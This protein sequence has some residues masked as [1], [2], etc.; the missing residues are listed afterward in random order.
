MRFLLTGVFVGAAFMLGALT[1]AALL[2]EPDPIG[3]PR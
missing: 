1:A 2:S 3:D